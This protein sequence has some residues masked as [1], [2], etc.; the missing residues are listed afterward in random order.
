M[1]STQTLQGSIHAT[2]LSFENLIFKVQTFINVASLCLIQ[3]FQLT[4]KLL[5]LVYWKCFFFPKNMA[6]LF[7]IH[8]GVGSKETIILGAIDVA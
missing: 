6:Y 3:T 4:Q 1:S 5:C 8:H 7:V 2:F